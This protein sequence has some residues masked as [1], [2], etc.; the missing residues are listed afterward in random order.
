M[1]NG[2][3]VLRAGVGGTIEVIQD[4]VLGVLDLSCQW[5]QI[6]LCVEV[7]ENAVVA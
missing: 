4:N 7:E 2:E 3:E 6:I 5:V 1:L